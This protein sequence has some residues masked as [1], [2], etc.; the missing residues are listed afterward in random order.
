MKKMILVL[1]VALGA[2]KLYQHTH[3]GQQV[4]LAPDGKP[5]AQVFVAPGCNQIC[6]QVVTFLRER[7]IHHELIDVTSS[8]GEK[9]NIS[10]IPVVRVGKREVVGGSRSAIVGWLAQV[11]GP[12]VLTP[13]EQ[14]VMQGHFDAQGKPRVVL[15][16]TSWCPYCKQQRE[17]FKTQGI[18]YDEV[19]VEG[20]AEAK[21]AF[22]ILHGHGYP[23]TYVGYK[24]FNQYTE[25]GIKEALAEMR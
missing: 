13:A 18:R 25:Q 10:R 9:Y 5:I 8:E 20:S 2:Y 15:Y 19:D 17:Y 21:L 1:L 6:D 11:Y 22:D 7:N 14:M 16:G 23:L 3:A 12:S 4:R 24:A